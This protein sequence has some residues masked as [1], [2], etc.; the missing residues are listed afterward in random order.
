MTQITIMVEADADLGVLAS[1]REIARVAPSVLSCPVDEGDL[2]LLLS[3]VAAN[4]VQAQ[5]TRLCVRMERST[6]STLRVAVSD[7]GEGVP[8]L[9]RPPSHRSSGRGLAIVDAISA[10]WGT[11]RSDFDR[12]TTVWFLLAVR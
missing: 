8:A 4:A 12:G 5:S 10:G 1:L 7:D 9:Q 11:H 3:E 2:S 6:P